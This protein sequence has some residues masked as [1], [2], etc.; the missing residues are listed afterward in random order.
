MVG[1]AQSTPIANGTNT[2]LPYNN[3]YQHELVILPNSPYSSL[4]RYFLTQG[5]KPEM[6]RNIENTRQ[7]I[8]WFWGELIVHPEQFTERDEKAG[9]IKLPSPYLMP[10]AKG[11]LHARFF[12]WDSWFTALPHIGTEREYLATGAVENCSYLFQKYNIIPNQAD[13]RFLHRSQPPV[14]TS[15]IMDIYHSIEK[16]AVDKLVI[17]ENKKWLKK[18]IT[19]AKKEYSTV[20]MSKHRDS[21]DEKNTY[22]HRKFEFTSLSNWGDRD[23]GAHY[24]AEYESGKDTTAE[25]AGRAADFLPIDLNCFLLKYERDFKE[26]AE[27]LGN[28]REAETWQKHIDLRISEMNKYFWD[29]ELGFYF[30]FDVKRGKK[31]EFKTLSG[32]QTLWCKL[33]TQSQADRMINNLSWFET[34]HGLMTTALDSCPPKF[35]T[36]EKEKLLAAGIPERYLETINCMLMP[37][38]WTAPNIWSPTEMM[39]V[40]GLIHYGFYNHA[41][42]IMQNAIVSLASFFEKYKTMPEK[43]NGLTGEGGG[44]HTYPDKSGFGWTNAEYVTFLGV[45]QKLLQDKPIN[46]YSDLLSF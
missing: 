4:Y 20:W 5:L 40:F 11:G 24:P 22:N 44:N 1:I 9:A 27:I 45:F 18:Y 15:M 37:G 31:D 14:L 35:S 12:Y 34:E 39:S 46:S 6:I 26:V 23:I 8:D 25:F 33:P 17:Q 2:L 19:I 29:E 41:K 42:R 43:R 3:P 36:L 7:Y 21:M 38:Q 32:F 28:K 16:Q 13:I 30:N 10:M